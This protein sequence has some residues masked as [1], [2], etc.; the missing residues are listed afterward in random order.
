MPRNNRTRLRHLRE[1]IEALDRRVPRVERVGEAAITK[2]A[3]VLRKRALERIAELECRAP[4]KA[5]PPSLV[6]QRS[7]TKRVQGMSR[8]RAL[9]R[10]RFPDLIS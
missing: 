9:D 6:V 1:L 5:P 10:R 4:T 3:A 8:W 7:G 2:D